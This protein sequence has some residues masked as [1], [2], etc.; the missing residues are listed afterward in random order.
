MPIMSGI[1][2][3]VQLLSTLKQNVLLYQWSKDYQILMSRCVPQKWLISKNNI[4][5]IN[6]TNGGLNFIYCVIYM[7]SA[8]QAVR[9]KKTEYLKAAKIFNVPRT[10]LFRLANQ[11]ELTMQEIISNK[12]GRKPVF[13]KDFEDIEILRRLVRYALIL[14]EKLYGLTQMDMRR[15]AYQLAVRNNVPNSFKDDRAGR[16]W[17]KGFLSRHK[18]ILSMRKSS[19]TSFARANGF[20]KQ[21]MNELYDNIEIVYDTKKFAADRI[22]NVDE[23]GLY[24]VQSK[25]PKVI[26]RGGKKRI[27]AIKSAGRGSLITIVTC[28]RPAS[29]FVLPMMIFP[30]KNMT[31]ISII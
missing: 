22:F 15:M 14:E 30:R 28:M 7:A 19:R 23:T 5:L 2:K 13:D 10:S 29:I 26:S 8:V 31:S 16:Y 27:G 3:Y 18:Q 1:L 9:E 24:I 25:F 11:K 12:I 4:F 6:T 21:R 20:T 17:L